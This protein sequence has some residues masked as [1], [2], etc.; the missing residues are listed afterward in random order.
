MV[1]NQQVD[2]N[3]QF[4]VKQKLQ[5]CGNWETE[6]VDGVYLFFNETVGAGKLQDSQAFIF[7]HSSVSLSLVCVLSCLFVCCVAVMTNSRWQK[8]QEKRH[9]LTSPC[10]YRSRDYRG[11]QQ[12]RQRKVKTTNVKSTLLYFPVFWLSF[13][14][15]F[16][17]FKNE[18][19]NEPVTLC[20]SKV[21]CWTYFE[22]TFS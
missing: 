18:H 16:M 3:R 10:L 9:L 5:E 19:L 12:T 13:N 11:S 7:C 6:R 2:I 8:R 4:N 21:S 20:L 15:S 22:P 14:V 17:R 1:F